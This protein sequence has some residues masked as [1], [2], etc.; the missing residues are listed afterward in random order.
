VLLAEIFA[1]KFKPMSHKVPKCLFPV[2]N[3]PLILYTLE[4]LALNNVKEVYVVSSHDNK[5]LRDK[6]DT[7]KESH[8]IGKSNNFKITYVKLE[9]ANS[10]ASA[11]R[12]VNDSVEL[13]D[14]FLVLQGD[15]V[16]NADLSGALRMHYK[17]KA[18]KE[19]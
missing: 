16:C 5:V 18:N 9:Q 4:F 19:Y 2:A 13:R 15:I 7:I 11:L 6:I 17:K 1:S 10:V 8:M 3:I 12:E 14:D